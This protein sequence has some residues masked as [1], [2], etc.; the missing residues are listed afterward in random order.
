ME[1]ALTP[2]QLAAGEDIH[3]NYSSIEKS[4]AELWR[5]EN[6]DPENAVT[7]AALW[8]VI[9]HT[10]TPH[11]HT[12]ASEILSKAAAA[13]PQRTIVIRCEP[14]G[15]PE[16]TSWISANCHLVSGKKQV[17]SEEVAIVAGGERIHHIAPIVRALLLPDMPVAMW[18]VGDL[19]NE[20]EEYVESLLRPVDTLIIDSSYFDRAEDFALISRVASRT[21][22][23]PADLNWVR[24]EEWRLATAAVFDPP[25]A[26]PRLRRIRKV[27]VVAVEGENAF[28]DVAEALMYVAWLRAQLGYTIDHQVRRQKRDQRAGSLAEI[29]LHFDDSTAASMQRDEARKVIFTTLDGMTQ[30]FDLV[31]RMAS[32]STDDLIVRQLKRTNGDAVLLKVLPIATEIAGRWSS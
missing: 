32:R 27:E 3:V 16:I 17:C 4:L 12:Q 19:P 23:A 24:L 10:S 1:T 25:T 7:R 14:D 31:T 13:V 21:R 11:F 18:W 22:T 8:N 5:S 6:K 29:N 30:S 28:G 20:R 9:A 26:R 2:D 15:A